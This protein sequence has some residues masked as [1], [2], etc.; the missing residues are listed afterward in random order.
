[1][2]ALFLPEW[3]ATI[4]WYDNGSGAPI[5]FLPGL[6]MPVAADFL[7]VAAD[8]VLVG[9]RCIL[10]DFLGS[11]QSDHPTGF[12]YAL[13]SHAAVIARVLEHLG[14]GPVD[15]VGHSMGGTVAIV[16][17]QTCPQLVSRLIVAEANV[18]PGGGLMSLRISRDGEQAFLNTGYAA[19][20]D[21]LRS[22][23]RDGAGPVD[24]IVAGWQVADP[25]GLFANAKALVDL[26]SDMF[27]G[28]A[29]LAIPKT[30]VYGDRSIGPEPTPDTPD[31]RRLDEAGIPTFTVPDAGHAMMIHNHA[32]FMDVLSKAL[33][34]T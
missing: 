23:V 6:G 27:D 14:T 34:L 12:D 13:N 19:L 3:D 21:S 20:L 9:R 15:V 26:P 25:K 32:G 4:R 16:L 8:P 1:M 28:F 18:D 29:G 2:N 5:L 7:A 31:R 11:G 33:C 17:A 22:K 30:F 24:R 10:V